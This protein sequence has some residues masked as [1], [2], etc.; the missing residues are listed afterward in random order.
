MLHLIDTPA[1]RR[2]FRQLHEEL[3]GQGFENQNL[4]RLLFGV[5]VPRIPMTE[6]DPFWAARSVTTFSTTNPVPDFDEIPQG[7]RTLIRVFHQDQSVP[8]KELEALLSTSSIAALVES[9]MM[10][11]DGPLLRPNVTLTECYGGLFAADRYDQFSKPDAAL[12][13]HVSTAFIEWFLP[14]PTPLS[15]AVDIG[16]GTGVLSFL[17]NRRYGATVYAVD[18]NPRAVEYAK[19]NAVMNDLDGVEIMEADHNSLIKEPSLAGKVDLLE[20]NMPATFWVH[21]AMCW[22]FPSAS[23][24]ERTLVDVYEALPKLFSPRGVAILR[25]ESKVPTSWLDERLAAVPGSEALQVLHSHEGETAH[26][27][28]K[29]ID[30]MHKDHW[31]GMTPLYDPSWVI[32]LAII[33]RRANPSDPLLGHLPVKSWEEWM[34]FNA[35]NWQQRI[36][37]MPGWA[38]YRIRFP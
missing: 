13:P 15:K 4:E 31:D 9:G 22:G 30:E 17:M 27:E 1:S 6:Q 29:E 18:K 10:S 26:L 38:D 32:G 37:A 8:R 34:A 33:R 23:I 36:A 3:K 20:W 19:F 11:E 16:T 21:E 35:D 24:G 7:L 14:A 25:H 28:R 5:V 2:R 12:R